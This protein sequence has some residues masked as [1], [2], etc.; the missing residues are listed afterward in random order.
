MAFKKP[1]DMSTLP[2]YGGTEFS[3]YQM[4]ILSMAVLHGG[5]GRANYEASEI[6]PLMFEGMICLDDHQNIWIATEEGEAA[7]YAELERRK[8]TKDSSPNLKPCGCMMAEDE[9]DSC[10]LCY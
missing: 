1:V 6:A 3:D 2:G 5:A 8:K 7:F 10:E 9:D 4:G